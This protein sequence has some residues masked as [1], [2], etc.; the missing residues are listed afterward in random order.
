MTEFISYDAISSP[1]C[2]SNLIFKFDKIP[3]LQ[4]VSAVSLKVLCKTGNCYKLNSE[5]KGPIVSLKN[6]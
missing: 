3:Q 2:K 5:T 6:V 1:I 4:R